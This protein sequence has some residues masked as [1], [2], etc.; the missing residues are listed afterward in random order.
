MTPSPLLRR[1]P[2]TGARAGRAVAVLAAAALTAGCGAGPGSDLVVTPANADAAQ[3]DAA[4]DVVHV[5]LAGSTIVTSVPEVHPGRVTLLVSNT[6]ATEQQLIVKGRAGQWETHSLAPGERTE[7]IVH[8][9]KTEVMKLWCGES[10]PAEDP[11]TTLTVL[12]S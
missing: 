8:A 10:G 6:A 1:R 2:P 7:L 4:S 3:V 11:H 5:G 9:T 12:P